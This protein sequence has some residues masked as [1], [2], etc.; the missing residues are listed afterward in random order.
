ML[1]SRIR[2]ET[3]AEREDE[4]NTLELE[5]QQQR[6]KDLKVARGWVILALVAVGIGVMLAA[7]I[8]IAVAASQGNNIKANSDQI[9]YNSEKIAENYV[10]EIYESKSYSKS[11]L[12][13]S[14]NLNSILRINSGT[15]QDIGE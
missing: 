4:N 13:H 3:A 2:R 14:W 1:E 12:R 6:R 7:I 15:V 9:A 5:I 10:L 11:L 8:G